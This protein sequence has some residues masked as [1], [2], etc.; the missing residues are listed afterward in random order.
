MLAF[1]VERR[2][3]WKPGVGA[4]GGTDHNQPLTWTAEKQVSPTE[5]I[6]TSE[7][8]EHWSSL[9]KQPAA[10]F[11]LEAKGAEVSQNINSHCNLPTCIFSTFHQ[12]GD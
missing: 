1:K 2:E 6:L 3:R 5:W 8:A 4:V 7:W 10:L 12:K 11:V 9:G